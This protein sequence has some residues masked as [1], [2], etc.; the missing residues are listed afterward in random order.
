MPNPFFDGFGALDLQPEPSAAEAF[1]ASAW[2]LS[3]ACNFLVQV[4]RLGN[5]PARAVL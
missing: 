4:H 5:V 3:Q 1:A 2:P